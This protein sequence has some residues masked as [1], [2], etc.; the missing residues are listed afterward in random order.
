MY[1]EALVQYAVLHD[2]VAVLG[3]H[4]AGA[5]GVPGGFDVAC[6]L[7]SV[8][9]AVCCEVGWGFNRGWGKVR[10]RRTLH[11]VLNMLNILLR[12]LKVLQHML[13][14]RIQPTRLR[15]LARLHRHG[16]ATMLNTSRKIP[17]KRILPI[18]ISIQ[19]KDKVVR[20]WRDDV[21]LSWSRD[22]CP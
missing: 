14:V 12:I 10:G 20:G 3:R 8:I 5:Q 13:R 7:T 18:H 9:G 1:V 15:R 11:P 21:R 17:F 16:P 2:G 6:G 22:P 4:G 19:T